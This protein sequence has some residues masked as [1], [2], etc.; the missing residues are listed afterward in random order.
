MLNLPID[1]KKIKPP[2]FCDGIIFS[3]AAH[4]Y[5]AILERRKEMFSAKRDNLRMVFEKARCVQYREQV[6][7][8]HINGLALLQRSQPS[9]NL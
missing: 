6:N 1:G 8:M 3:I 4:P 5:A 9:R 2:Q 7:L